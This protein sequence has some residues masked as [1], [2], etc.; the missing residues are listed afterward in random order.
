MLCANIHNGIADDITCTEFKD[1]VWCL[2]CRL[3]KR[4]LDLSSFHL[5]SRKK[6]FVLPLLSHQSNCAV[7]CHTHYQRVCIH[8]KQHASETF[9]PCGCSLFISR[10]ASGLTEIFNRNKKHP[11]WN[12]PLIR[13]HLNTCLCTGL[14]MMSLLF[15]CVGWSGPKVFKFYVACFHIQT[16]TQIERISQS[17]Q[18]ETLPLQKVLFSVSFIS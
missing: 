14:A 8:K 10:R 13:R 5:C 1:L 2:W 17:R 6:E 4:C 7:N 18:K 15:T 12:S 16:T 11:N 9:G 3:A